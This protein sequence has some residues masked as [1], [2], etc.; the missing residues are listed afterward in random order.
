MSRVLCQVHKVVSPSSVFNRPN[1]PSKTNPPKWKQYPIQS[2]FF[3]KDNA[4]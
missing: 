2:N 4:K 1:G 3:Y